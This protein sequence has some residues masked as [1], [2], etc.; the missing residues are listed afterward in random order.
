MNG[1]DKIIMINDL[2]TTDIKLVSLVAPVYNE[3]ANLVDLV[4]R[5][6][7][8]GEA[9]EYDY[10]IILVDDG[11]IDSSVQMIEQAA[12][13]HKGKVIGVLLNRNYGQHSAVMAGLAQS[14]GDVVVTL[15]ADLQN[16]PEEI[17]KLLEKSA[18][19]CDVV[20]SVRMSRKDTFFR[21][22]ASKVINKA[23]QKATGVMMTDYGC[24][25]RAYHRNIVDAMLQC[26]ERS[27]F[28]PVLANTFARQPCEV[29][30]AHADRSQDETKYSLMKLI[31]L[32]FDLLT[33]MTT[34][35][36]RLLSVLGGLLA[37]AGFAFSIILLV[38]RFIYGADW[39]GEGVFTVFAILFIFIGVQLLAMGLLGEYIGRIY[40]D[41][42]ARPRY[43][44]HKVVGVNK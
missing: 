36:L 12:E 3:E 24:M 29:Q 17:P 21:R 26:H 14:R 42:R 9:L 43:F 4:S 19:G 40:H 39:A 11:S 35:P 15:D 34:F 32:Q 28:I 8:V 23:V 20:G 27:T 6:V 5:C 10:E 38:T 30:V 22:A 33:S 31:N 25:L 16:P 18:L 1:S 13:E 44:I 41:V 37:M 7:A 2:N